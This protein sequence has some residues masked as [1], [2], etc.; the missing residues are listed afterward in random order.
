[1][2]TLPDQEIEEPVE[3]EASESDEWENDSRKKL[4]DT[5]ERNNTSRSTG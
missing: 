4:F 1:V 2:V 5:N 3:E